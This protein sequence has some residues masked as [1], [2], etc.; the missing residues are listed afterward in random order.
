LLGAD[1][2]ARL[3]AHAWVVIAD[4]TMLKVGHILGFDGP[5]QHSAGGAT[6]RWAT[7]FREAGR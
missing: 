4:G 1:P 3:S 2:S 7:P 5:G 6:N